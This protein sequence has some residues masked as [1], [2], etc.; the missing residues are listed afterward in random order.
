MLKVIEDAARTIADN[1]DVTIRFIDEL[2]DST[3]V[4]FTTDSDERDS[5]EE[6]EQLQ[7]IRVHT[8]NGRAVVHDAVGSGDGQWD[9]EGESHFLNYHDGLSAA[10]QKIA[11]N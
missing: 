7:V 2:E 11:T 6:G 4:A 8:D 10:A 9:I 1:H 3:M 5:V